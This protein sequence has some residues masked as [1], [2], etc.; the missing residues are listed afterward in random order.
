MSENYKR[1]L[2]GII[3]ADMLPFICSE[4]LLKLEGIKTVMFSTFHTAS[5]NRMMEVPSNSMTTKKVV[6]ENV[7]LLDREY[8]EFTSSSH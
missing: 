1:T 4:D 3:Q 2:E 6:Q 7:L 5:Q 8:N